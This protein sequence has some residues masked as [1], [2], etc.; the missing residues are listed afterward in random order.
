MLNQNKTNVE[1][2]KLVNDFRNKKYQEYADQTKDRIQEVLN[3]KSVRD[4]SF[5]AQQ[6]DI[7]IVGEDVNLEKAYDDGK[8]AFA[9]YAD[10]DG[11]FRITK[12]NGDVIEQRVLRKD[13]PIYFYYHTNGKIYGLEGGVKLLGQ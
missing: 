4:K 12:K 3:Y 6:K 2:V 10:A 9:G 8:L 5:F 7:T 11:I 1:A 13:L